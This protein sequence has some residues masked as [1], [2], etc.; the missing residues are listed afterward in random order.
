MTGSAN[1]STAAGQ[2][3]IASSLRSSQMT[4]DSR[5]DLQRSIIK[6][7]M[8]AVAVGADIFLAFQ[9]QLAGVGGARLAAER[10]VIRV[11][12]GFGAGKALFEIGMNDAGG[13][14]RLGATV[15][16]PGPRLLRADR[17]IGDEVEQL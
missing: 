14:G 6:P 13:G 9:P 8:H 1:Q 3:W 7:E 2:D 15:D 10:N 4:V 16:G 12:N 5:T 11:R 17:E